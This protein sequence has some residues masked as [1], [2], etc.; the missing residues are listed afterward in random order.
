MSDLLFKLLAAGA[1]LGAVYAWHRSEVADEV[2]RVNSKATAQRR[3]EVAE[4]VVDMSARNLKQREANEAEKRALQESTKTLVEK[5]PVYVTKLADSRCVV[6][7]GFVQH[8][9]AAWGMPAV[10]G[11]ADRPVDADSGIPLS[12]VES[13]TTENAGI[14]R[15]ARAESAAWRAWYRVEST[16]YGAFA[17]S[18]IGKPQNLPNPAR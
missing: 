11:I 2:E 18:T 17:R 12:R 13:V 16:K 10:P 4:F 3:A 8:Y 14:C 9:V 15:E 1:L 6:P 5:V 7:A